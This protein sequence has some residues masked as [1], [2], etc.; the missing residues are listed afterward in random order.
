MYEYSGIHYDLMQ[1]K[2]EL[3]KESKN[4]RIKRIKAE[5]KELKKQ[6]DYLYKLNNEILEEIIKKDY[7]FAVSVTKP[8][9]EWYGGEELPNYELQVVHIPLNK[10]IIDEF[11]RKNNNFLKIE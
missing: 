10:A 7:T 1:I 3:Q 8:Y 11:Y 4:Q 6:I 2:E 9:A 5:N